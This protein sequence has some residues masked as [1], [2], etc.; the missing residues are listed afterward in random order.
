MGA[1]A[2]HFREARKDRL[3]RWPDEL[4]RRQVGNLVG[5]RI[6]AQCLR[7]GDTTYQEVVAPVS[8][9]D[10][11]VAEQHPAGETHQLA[12]GGQREA[13]TERMHEIAQD[14]ADAPGAEAAY[15]QRP[16]AAP[17][18]GQRGGHDHGNELAYQDE[19][20]FPSEVELLLKCDGANVLE[21]GNQRRDREHVHHVL[22]AWIAEEPRSGYRECHH[23]DGSKET[24]KNVERPRS[25]V[26]AAL[27][28]LVL[29]QGKVEV[30][31]AEDLQQAEDRHRERN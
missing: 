19:L 8:G 11:Q 26:V 5:N 15:G 25:V 29:Y 10:Y 31:R 30:E 20:E 22:D 1:V 24:V 2:R 14:D 21:A 9:I 28:P 16:I 12:R 17:G 4:C 18:D 3:G 13:G 27:R 7:A 23:Y 6:K